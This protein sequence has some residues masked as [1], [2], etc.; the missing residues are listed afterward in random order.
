MTLHQFNSLDETELCMV[1][2]IV[3]VLFPVSLVGEIPPRGLTWFRKGVL[4]E[5]IKAA[6]PQVKNEA[7]PIFSSLLTKLGV[8][9]EI[10]YEQPPQPPTGSA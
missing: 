6:F 3:N 5:K 2:Y 9:H 1:L 7:H 10:K 8:Q 4:E